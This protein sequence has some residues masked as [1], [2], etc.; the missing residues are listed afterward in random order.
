M[1]LSVTTK[2]QNSKIESVDTYFNHA[3]Y[4]APLNDNDNNDHNIQKQQS[5]SALTKLQE[6]HTTV[7]AFD[8]KDF[9]Q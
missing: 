2:M 5:K 1:G 7:K 9:L 4:W 8:K 3:N 6:H